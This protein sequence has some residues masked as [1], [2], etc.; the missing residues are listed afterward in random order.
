MTFDRGGPT[1]A[2]EK[3]PQPREIKM[4]M[5]EGIATGVYA[6]AM[7]VQ[8]SKQEFA[9]DFACVVGANGQVVS[10]VITTPEHLKR[11]LAAMQDSLARYERTFGK[12]AENAQ[13]EFKIGFQP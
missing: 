1:L 7:L 3:P 11:M 12:V 2:A 6:N 5:P 13:P 9:L 8:H 10:R 4:R